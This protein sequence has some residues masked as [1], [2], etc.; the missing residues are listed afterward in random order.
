MGA[1]AHTTPLT[2]CLQALVMGPFFP[3]PVVSFDLN[4]ELKVI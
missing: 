2:T 1:L 4:V 3:E